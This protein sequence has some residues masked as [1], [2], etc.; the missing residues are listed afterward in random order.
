MLNRHGILSLFAV[1]L[2]T[3][4]WTSRATAIAID[5]G[6]ITLPNFSN[7]GNLN[8]SI[9][10]GHSRFSTS[11]NAANA[12]DNNAGTDWA[13]A[14]GTGSSLFLDLDLTPGAPNGANVKSFTWDNRPGSLDFVQTMQIT[15]SKDSTF[16]NPDDVTFG[17]LNV[18][19]AG[20]VTHSFQ[21]QLAKFVRFQS[22]T[23]VAGFN[24]GAT[25]I[26]LAGSLPSVTGPIVLRDFFGPGQNLN[27]ALTNAHSQFNGSFSALNAFDNNTSTDWATLGGTGGDLFIDIDISGAAGEQRITGFTWDNRNGSLDFVQTMQALLS[28]DNVFGNADDVIVGPFN[29]NGAGP[30]THNF[31]G[32][33]ANFIRLQSLTTVAGFNPGAAEIRLFGEQIVPEPAAATLGLIA[34]GGLMLRRHR[35]A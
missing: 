16:G 5:T 3:L 18:D 9:V 8:A 21:P 31:P 15:L 2:L 1:T 30:F 20:P 27:A 26:R 22:L 4:A 32:V 33:Q 7:A 19:G 23:T 11:F 35:M 34:L 13:T 28:I 12:F 6:P 24:P 10:G 17:P 25:E 29:V 14:G